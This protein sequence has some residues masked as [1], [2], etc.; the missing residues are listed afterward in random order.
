MGG[1]DNIAVSVHPFENR[2]STPVCDICN[3]CRA[4]AGQRL[5][6]WFNNID[7]RFI[8]LPAYID[9]VILVQ[10]KLGILV[11][12]VSSFQCRIYVCFAYGVRVDKNPSVWI[13]VRWGQ[14]GRAFAAPVAAVSYLYTVNTTF[15]KNV[16]NFSIDHCVEIKSDAVRCCPAA[17]RG[18]IY[19]A[20]L[21]RYDIAGKIILA[22]FIGV[23]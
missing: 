4:A 9:L 12:L 2:I 13:A 14:S 5:I 7:I 11:I 23:D 20:T 17:Y 3:F 21:F 16:C 19:A 18:T 15:S 8:Y 1:E 10:R 22:V 6:L